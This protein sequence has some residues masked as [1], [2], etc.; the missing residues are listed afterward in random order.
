MFIAA[1]FTIARTSK[2]TKCPSTEGWIKKIYIY[3]YNAILLN[4]KEEQNWIICRDMDRPRA[5]HKEGSMPERQKQILYMNAY[6]WNLE[7]LHR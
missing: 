5:C 2:Q 1:L 3:T 6:M 7:K 4:H